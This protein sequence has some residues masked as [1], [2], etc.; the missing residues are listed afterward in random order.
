MFFQ[1]RL[2]LRFLKG[3]YIMDGKLKNGRAWAN[4]KAEISF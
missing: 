1:K 4:I 2:I 3:K